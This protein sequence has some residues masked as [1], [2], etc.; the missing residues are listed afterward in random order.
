V[1]YPWNCRA[2][3]LAAMGCA[4]GLILSAADV[5]KN[6]PAKGGSIERIKVHG[7]PLEGN[8]EGNSPDRD[9]AV[10]LPPS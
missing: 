7:K 5:G 3:A 4:A 6:A 8:L 10:Y 2:I 1:N 9:V